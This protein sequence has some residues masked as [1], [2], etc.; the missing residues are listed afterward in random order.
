M[1]AQRRRRNTNLFWLRHGKRNLS[2][3]SAARSTRFISVITSVAVAAAAQIG[4]EMV[5]FVRPS[6]RP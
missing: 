6:A 2:H 3:C 1:I 4:A 5:I